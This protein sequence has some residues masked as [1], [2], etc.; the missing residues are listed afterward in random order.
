MSSSLAVLNKILKDDTRIKIIGL[1]NEKGSITYTELLNSLETTSTGL[2]NYHLKVLG[3][4]LAKNESGEYL[5]TEKGKVAFKLITEFPQNGE[6]QRHVW[7]R[8]F[9]ISMAVFQIA[10]F[11]LGLTFYYL[12]Y[13]DLFRFVSITTGFVIGIISVYFIW[14]MVRNGMPAPGTQQ[15]H[16]RIKVAYICGGM[17]ISLVLAFFGVGITL[18]GISDMQGVRFTGNNPLYVLFWSTPYLVFSLLIVPALGACIAYYFG[19]KNGFEQ[20]KWAIWIQSHI[21]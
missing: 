19:K 4:L 7:R 3:D 10:Y 16:Q 20:P 1:V 18:R 2:L 11:S 15:M 6:A 21:G 5:L 9:W 14:R 17:V 8:R 13:I 12:H